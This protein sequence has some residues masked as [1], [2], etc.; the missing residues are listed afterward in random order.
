M[1]T[2][3]QTPVKSLDNPIQSG[4]YQGSGQDD[5]PGC[6]D[7]SGF[8]WGVMYEAEEGRVC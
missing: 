4:T 1:Y 5:P 8:N 3:N 7:H 2:A 6:T